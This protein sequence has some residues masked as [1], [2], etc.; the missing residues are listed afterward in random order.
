MQYGHKHDALSIIR[1][2]INRVSW[3]SIWPCT[4][5]HVKLVN[6]LATVF[7]NAVHVLYLRTYSA[8]SVKCQARHKGVTTS[9]NS[10]VNT[11]A[12]LNAITPGCGL[13]ADVVVDRSERTLCYCAVAH[14]QNAWHGGKLSQRTNTNSITQHRRA[15]H[16]LEP[17]TVTKSNSRQ[18]GKLADVR[19]CSRLILLFESERFV[20]AHAAL[21]RR[22]RWR[23]H[24]RC[25]L[26][27]FVDLFPP[28]SWPLTS[29]RRGDRLMSRSSHRDSKR[30]FRPATSKVLCVFVQLLTRICSFVRPIVRSFVTQMSLGCGVGCWWSQLH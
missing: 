6:N 10:S 2:R 12:L 4:I 9:T 17:P 25:R 19:N 20:R 5:A 28:T 7:P 11:R 3:R 18:P 29:T 24:S 15:F 1:R 21:R 8:Q 26:R 23:Y 22:I 16:R 27:G 14:E 30:K 13:A